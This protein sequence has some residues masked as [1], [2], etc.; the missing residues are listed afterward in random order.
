[1][2]TQWP[3]ETLDELVDDL[4]TV[5]LVKRRRLTR[6]AW[7]DGLV[8][9]TIVRH[10]EDPKAYRSFERRIVD[11]FVPHSLIELELVHRLANLLWRLRRASAIEAGFFEINHKSLTPREQPCGSLPPAV[12][13]NGHDK[14]SGTGRPDDRSRANPK[15]SR[16]GSLSNSR[17]IT[18]CFLRLSEHYPA[19]LDRLGAYEAR[20]WRQAAQTIWT[21]EMLRRAAST[22]RQRPY[23]KSR[24]RSWHTG[25]W[26]S[27]ASLRDPIE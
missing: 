12:R 23:R 7:R 16:P 25:T 8:A 21:L 6:K 11:S 2:K 15:P 18:E 27:G 22:S 19:L 3:D 4:G 10:V 24:A 1:M 5:G 20:L 17:T 9:Q 14:V 13:V 26:L